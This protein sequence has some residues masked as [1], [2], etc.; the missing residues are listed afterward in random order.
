MPSIIRLKNQKKSKKEPLK[1]LTREINDKKLFELNS[2]LAKINW[3]PI[4]TPLDANESF[5]CFHN[6]LKEACEK[7]IPQKE[8]TINY[9][10]IIRDPW[11]TAGLCKCLNKQ[12][13]LYKDTLLNE[14]NQTLEK[15]RTYQNTLQKL[16][17]NCK[18]QHYLNKCAEFKNN[19]RKLW[20]LINTTILKCNNKTDSIDRIK[21]EN[22]YKTDANSIT[23]SL[24]KHFASV[25]K[26][27]ADRIPQSN[28]SVDNYIQKIT[29]N[30]KSLF[31][32]PTTEQEINPLITALPNKM[33]SGYDNVN[34]ILLKQI[35]TN[36]VKP[37]NMIINK[38][39]AEGKFP[40]AMKLADV[41]PLFK[42]KDK[43]DTNNKKPIFLLLTLSKLL[44]KVMYEC[45][46][47]FLTD[48]D[49]IYNS[50]YGF[51]S[52]HSC[53]NA[54]SELTSTILKGFQQNEFTLGH[55]LDLSNAFNMLDHKILLKKLAKYGIQSLALEWFESYLTDWKIR[56][57]C[58][59]SSTGKTEYFSYETIS[60]GTPQGSCLGPYLIFTNDL[61]K[62]LS[63]C[64]SIMFADDTTLY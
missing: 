21:V 24:C 49:Q 36:I 25:G 22:I 32:T 28:T 64:N 9:N 7:M 20:D 5:N 56:V 53:E 50:Q 3:D 34:N 14:S 47:H 11:L 51:R 61:A 4:L 43:T 48:T 16:V 10:Q 42:S 44:G 60:C 59:V 40:Q 23:S 31:L 33:S 52:G 37:L 41:Y 26:S 55:F 18:S 29:G 15:Y 1:I 38:S 17:R 12:K 46:Y 57:K 19:S 13:H 58:L 30:N 35:K 27:Y 45:I 62:H 63:H 39:F 8:K 2:M 54:V 6:Q